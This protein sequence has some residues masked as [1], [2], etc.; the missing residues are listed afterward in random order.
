[1][2]R[3]LGDVEV[4]RH[5]P[6]PAC[7]AL[8]ARD[9]RVGQRLAHRIQR[10]RRDRIL[11]ARHGGLRGE[12]SAGDRV[13]IEEELLDRILRQSVGIIGIGIAA[14]DPEDPLGEHVGPRVG[15]P[16]RRPR[17]GQCLCQG[18]SGRAIDRRP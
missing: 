4:D 3:I 16:R 8:M 13:A 17:V 6:H 15:H 9:H 5:A 14:R 10:P 1:M 12:P 7:P 11:E 2:R 18:G